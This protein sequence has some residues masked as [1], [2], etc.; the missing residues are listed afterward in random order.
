MITERRFLRP[1][2]T[3]AVHFLL[4]VTVCILAQT[5][6]C[7]AQA[8][9]PPPAAAPSISTSSTPADKVKLDVSNAH[10]LLKPNVAS[11]FDFCTGQEVPLPKGKFTVSKGLKLDTAQGKCGDLSGPAAN[12]MVTGGNPPYHF[13]LDTMGGFPPIGMHLGMN[14][15]L[16]GTPTAKPPLG[17]WPSF[18][19]CAVDMSGNSDCP[20]VQ[21]ESPTV[22]PHHGA[23]GKV[24]ALVVGVAAIGGVA[25]VAAGSKSSSGG[26]AVNGECDGM[27]S[28]NAC[29]A[30]SCDYNTTCNV[31]GAVAACG[32]G[33]CAVS[34]PN[35][36][37]GAP[38]CP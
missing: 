8:A 16:Y 23:N 5:T 26:G 32:S 34:G 10:P 9:P 6:F 20:K 19:V 27:S 2:L 24:L 22:P 29:G 13:Q 36:S 11:A 38:F 4:L 18:A 15:L 7:A 12:S 28:V 37:T 21:V 25:A 30:C 14:G 3:I 17:G 31:P 1:A 35:G 33:Y